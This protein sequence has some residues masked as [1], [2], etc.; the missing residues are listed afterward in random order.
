[1]KFR[2]GILVAIG[3][4]LAY[5]L[6]WPVPIDPVV[7][8]PGKNPGL[9]GDF[10]A[11]DLLSNADLPF[12]VL[13]QGPEDVTHGADGY[14]YT[15][16]LD[17]R[18]IRFTENGSET[19]AD[20]KGRPLGMAF[21]A[22]GQLIVADATRG[23]I[24]VAPDGTVNVL[25]D[26]VDGERLRLVDDLDIAMDGTIW[27]SDASQRFPVE[28]YILDFWEGRATGRLLSYEPSTGTTRVRM[29]GLMFANGVALGPDDG[30][31]LV[32]ETLAAR[33]MRLW[34]KGPLAGRS[35]VFI[36]NLPGYP[37]NL[38]FNGE[39]MFWIAM[40]SDRQVALENLAGSPWLRKL[41][42][43][44][45]ASLREIELPPLGWAIGVDT[46]GQIRHNLQDRSGKLF[47]ITSVNQIDGTLY[48]GSIVMD[49]V[50]RF[51]SQRP[52]LYRHDE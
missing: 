32:N 25:V 5:L 16:L 4:L 22:R 36:E 21:D 14:F 27:F 52:K 47:T 34:L 7:W 29:E 41:L 24:S 13:G 40:P 35:D 12:A 31:V 19:Y 26:E 49:T 10:E 6:L 46:D 17:G 15:G 48:F 28:Q 2:I 20:T 43:R 45:P 37:D 23:L 11:N 18:I 39:E 51:Q 44:L 38:S 42:W 9:T 1:M 33:V 8:Q 30:F 50:G 3:L